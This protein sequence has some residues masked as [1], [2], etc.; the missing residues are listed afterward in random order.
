VCGCVE[1]VVFSLLCFEVLVDE[2]VGV[3]YLVCD[4]AV[5]VHDVLVAEF[6][7]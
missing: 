3:E 6:L 5:E 4:V 1:F 2:L 7:E